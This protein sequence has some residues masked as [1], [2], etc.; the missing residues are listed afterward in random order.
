MHAVVRRVECA[1][2]VCSIGI[3]TRLVAQLGCHARTNLSRQGRLGIQTSCSHLRIAVRQSVNVTL[4]VEIVS[5][6]WGSAQRQ[7]ARGSIVQVGASLS[8]Q[9]AGRQQPCIDGSS[10]QMRV[11]GDA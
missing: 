3:V 5:H 6:Q 4:A 8:C 9:S 7:A 1:D 2:Q 10:D 11:E